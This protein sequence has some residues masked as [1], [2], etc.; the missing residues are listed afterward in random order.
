MEIGELCTRDVIIAQESASPGELARLMREFHS[1]SV[2]ITR[3]IAGVRKPVGI[4]TDRDIVIE[5]VAKD[6]PVNSCVAGD[7]MSAP[8]ST[9]LESAT[10]SE[11]LQA[12]RHQ[13]VRRMPVIDSRGALVGIITADDV[14]EHL[15]E[16]MDDL[17][18]IMRREQ[19]REQISRR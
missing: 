10:V 7:I 17:V 1:G 8:V 11:V 5:L 4:V 13:G 6:A 16:Q 19:S 9:V 15:R 12:M 14:V 3:E 18:A 2:V